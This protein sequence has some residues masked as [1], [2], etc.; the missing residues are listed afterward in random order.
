MLI[1]N[2]REPRT[3]MERHLDLVTHKGKEE[4]HKNQVR[5]HWS[6]A[7]HRKAHHRAPFQQQTTSLHNVPLNQSAHYASVVPTRLQASQLTPCHLRVGTGGHSY[8]M[9]MPWQEWRNASILPIW[10]NMPSHTPSSFLRPTCTAT[11]T[12]LEFISPG[13]STPWRKDRYKWGGGVLI[14]VKDC[15]TITALNLPENDAEIIW[16][17]VFLRGNK[18]LCLGAYYH[19]PD[20]NATSQKE[21]FAESLK[22]VQKITCNRRDITITLGGD[23][24]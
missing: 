13:Y 24:L 17:E 23:K 14:T 4:V 19:T 1:L 2:W 16:G 11:C 15:Y 6:S 22:E 12:T 10:W 18:R 3:H 5:H 7:L 20:G 21:A 8:W 9:P